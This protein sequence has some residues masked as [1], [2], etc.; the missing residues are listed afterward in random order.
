M[1]ELKNRNR[2]YFTSVRWL[3]VPQGSTMI[4]EGFLPEVVTS[5]NEI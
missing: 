3:G 1:V 4:A 5:M 2:G